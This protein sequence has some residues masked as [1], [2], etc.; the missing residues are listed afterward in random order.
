MQ[1]ANTHI[2]DRGIDMLRALLLALLLTGCTDLCSLHVGQT[3]YK[4]SNGIPGKVGHVYPYLS[5]CEIGVIWENGEYE[6]L[7]YWRVVT[8][9]GE[10]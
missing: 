9:I 1:T 8:D 3:V 4:A 2:T 5:A 7:E 6:Q 10:E